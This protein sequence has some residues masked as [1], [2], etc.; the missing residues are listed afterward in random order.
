VLFDYVTTSL[1]NATID[2]NPSGWVV[3]VSNSKG[4]KVLY[5]AVNLVN[6]AKKGDDAWM[7]SYRS[8]EDGATPAGGFD[9]TAV[10]NANTGMYPFATNNVNAWYATY[11]NVVAKNVLFSVEYQDLKRESTGNDLNKTLM[12]K[13]EF[14]Y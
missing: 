2:D 7:I 14:F 3:Q 4:P 9:T 10:A 5:P 11:Q 8:V 12:T 6:P 1:D 13:L